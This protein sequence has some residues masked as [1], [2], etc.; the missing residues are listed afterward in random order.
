MPLLTAS[1]GKHISR[2]AARLRDGAM[3][4]LYPQPCQLCG[5]GVE[6]WRDG[7]T[8]ARCWDETLTGE[9]H[10]CEKCG[11]FVPRRLP[12][13]VAE[14]AAFRCGACEMHAF[15]AARAGGRYEGA[16]RLAV[17]RLKTHPHLPPRLRALLVESFARFPARE[18][19]EGVVPVPLHPSRLRER[20]FNQAELLARALADACDLPL[21]TTSLVRAKATERH[22]SG[23]D[24][25]SRADSLRAAFRVRA[26][27]LIEGRSLLLVDDT[28][29]T[30]ATAD[31]IARTLAAAGAG[32]VRVL[33][34][35]RAASLFD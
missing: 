34:L 28:M 8:C 3:A 25:E 16:L 17:L 13:G 21:D 33:T 11:V 10:V 2:L 19:V 31:E 7:V 15:A 5:A 4:L 12:A 29:T 26:P 30:G 18:S 35:A 22:R 24:A 32:E 20:G 23:M 6:S 1:S 14:A 27:R 9:F